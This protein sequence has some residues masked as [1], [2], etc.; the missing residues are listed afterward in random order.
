MEEEN[1][2]QNVTIPTEVPMATNIMNQP[3][4]TKIVEQPI[5]VNVKD[6]SISNSP[7]IVNHTISSANTW[8][9]ITL[10]SGTIK[11]FTISLRGNHDFDYAYESSPSAYI[12]VPS[13]M[14]ISVDKT[15]PALYVRCS[16]ANYVIQV[17]FW[18]V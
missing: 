3:I 6:I 14:F 18:V 17:E 15:P 5:D 11:E 4:D 2:V 1:Y 7:V 16:S 12:N 9:Q 13:G 10:P 8:E